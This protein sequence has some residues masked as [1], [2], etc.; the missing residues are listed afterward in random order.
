MK[1]LIPCLFLLTVSFPAF[2]ADPILPDTSLTPGAVLTTD[3]ARV[4]QPDYSKSVRHT[5]SK[6]KEEIYREYHLHK[7]TGHYE[8]DHLIPLGLGGADVKENLWPESYHSRTWNAHTKD[9]LEWKLHRMVCAQEID[10]KEAQ[11]A[12]AANWITSF[13]HFCPTDDDCPSYKPTQK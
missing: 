8:I 9:R 4:C 10:I 3:V 12:F 11:Q 1:H 7:G 2:A 5:S 6:L 13:Q